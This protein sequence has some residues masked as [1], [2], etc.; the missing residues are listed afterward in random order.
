MSGMRQDTKQKTL[1]ASILSHLWLLI[2]LT[3]IAAVAYFL[4]TE[5]KSDIEHKYWVEIDETNPFAPDGEGDA[6]TIELGP[7]E[8]T[9]IW[10]I[11]TNTSSVP[12]YA[13]YVC[14]MPTVVTTTAESEGSEVETG[15]YEID[16][17]WEL[18]EEYKDGDDWIE[19]YGVWLAVEE[20]SRLAETMTMRE[21]SRTTYSSI[22]DL[23]ISMRGFCVAA[24]P[25]KDD[26]S[27]YAHSFADAWE[28]IQ[29]HI[30]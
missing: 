8:S 24:E 25:V 29:D 20:G 27:S 10:P 26:A 18:V 12:V 5:Y 13:L 7:G 23:N 4:G 11:L 9:T 1:L 19:V 17:Q 21:I 30:Q 2:P 28:T 22:D 15:L 6:V 14:R 3:V 16:A